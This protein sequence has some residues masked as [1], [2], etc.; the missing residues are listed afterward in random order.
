MQKEGQQPHWHMPASPR[1]DQPHR[2][3]HQ[4]Q[5]LICLSNLRR[6]YSTQPKPETLW[7]NNEPPFQCF[8]SL[9]RAER[10][11]ST[12]YRQTLPAYVLLVDKANVA[13]GVSR[14]TCSLPS[15]EKAP[16][17]TQQVGCDWK[18][19]RVHTL[20]ATSVMKVPLSS[21]GRHPQ[22]RQVPVVP[23]PALGSGR[24]LT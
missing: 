21:N 23:A 9:Q 4:N 11:I 22:W 3:C 13:K 1:R 6:L 20:N 2:S 18:A 8:R 15:C 5:C 7:G 10:P 12:S 17:H 24:R 19:T 16:Q 14:Q